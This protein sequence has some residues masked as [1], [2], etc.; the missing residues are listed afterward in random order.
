MSKETEFYDQIAKDVKQSLIQLVS[1]A[2]HGKSSSLRTIIAYCKQKHPDIE[3]VIFDISQA[4]FHR[5]PVRYRQLITRE[6]L[7]NRKYA[8]ITD[9]VYEIGKLGKDERREFVADIIGKH[10]DERYE[11]AMN[12]KGKVTKPTLI[13][14]CEEA[15]VYFGSYAL[16]RNDDYTHVFDQFL[17]VGR[18]YK[19][20]G[21]FVATAEMGE[22]SPNVRDRTLKIYGKLA[23]KRDI[24]ELRRVDPELADYLAKDI[25]RF[26]FVY[27]PG[28][29]YG[30]VSIPDVVKNVPIDYVVPE[31]L[32]RVIVAPVVTLPPV[33]VVSVPVTRKSKPASF[34]ENFL[35]GAIGALVLIYVL[36]W[37]F[38]LIFS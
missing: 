14:V 33:L 3:W 22:I 20:R 35:C 37:L 4:W 24:A 1:A 36:N 13:F 11:E 27:Y 29:T 6:K 17:S 5:A 15:N 21:I 12:N 8:N 38:T 34:G 25:P 7:A 10:Y 2:G 16:R 30:P 9:C 32:R 28:E 18:N 31:K 26:S 23:S 19:M